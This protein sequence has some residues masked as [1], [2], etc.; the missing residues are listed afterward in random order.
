MPTSSLPQRR[1]RSERVALYSSPK[2][3]ARFV[4]E[5]RRDHQGL[6][7][8][9]MFLM[10]VGMGTVTQVWNPPFPFRLGMV[11]SR[12]I[13]CNTTFAVESP[14]GRVRAEERIRSE[15]PHIYFNDSQLLVQLRESLW[16]TVAVL[17]HVPDYDQL[18]A[19]GKEAWR[20][21]LRPSLIERELTRDP[22]QAFDEFY[23]YFK[24]DPKLDRFKA[25]LERV[26]TPLEVYGVLTELNFGPT[27]GNQERIMVYRLG[28][29]PD[30]AVSVKVSDALIRDG[31]RL[32]ELLRWEMQ[33]EPVARRIFQWICSQLRET[34]TKDDKATMNAINEAVAS[35]GVVMLEYV[36]GK[37]LVEMGTPLGYREIALLQA[38]YR[39]SLKK[40]TSQQQGLRF[41]AIT[42]MMLVLFAVC[43]GFVQRTERR[44]PKSR[45][46]VF[47][48]LGG[49][50]LTVA[51]AKGLDAYSQ[52]IA[53]WEM[54]PL[55][56]FVQL[57]SLIYSW[58]LAIVLST[59]LILFLAIGL[60][61]G[62]GM[63]IILLGTTVSMA[64]Q[65]GRLHF[66]HKLVVVSLV[67]GIVAFVLTYSVGILNGR[68]TDWPLFIESALNL[69][70]TMLA[71]VIMTALLPFVEEMFG[72]LTD[73]SLLELGNVSHPLL[74]SLVRLAPATYGHSM[75]VGTIAETAAEAVGARSLM[76]RV[77]AYYHDI[78][79]IMNPGYYSE[80]Q[81]GTGNIHDHLEPQVSTIVLVAHVKD[82]VDLVRQH[83]LPYP[84]IELVEQH[85]GTTVVSFFY[86]K[87]TTKAKDEQLSG[88]QQTVEESTFRY[89]GPKPQSKEAAILMIADTCESAC[90]SMREIATP[91]RLENKV[92]ALIKQKLD[93]GQLDDS[94]LT[95]RELKTIEN[96]VIKSVIAAF[97]GRVKYPGQEAEEAAIVK[98]EA[99]TATEKTETVADKTK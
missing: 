40:R 89:P 79:K 3:R 66:R 44:R 12:S 64:L 72:V 38:E 32:F 76:T 52:E 65:L 80:N 17:V 46:A 81:G 34:L 97:H 41:G 33:S 68:S 10:I 71:G 50:F 70:W 88:I 48:M 53:D 20:D 78:G 31:G 69:L 36:P 61:F 23:E 8:A 7:F 59:V 95:L 60:G 5:I 63:L 58:E 39:E 55:L 90:R 87:A 1:T 86:G 30:S 74:Q 13:I 84:I 99:A 2:S 98:N 57:V 43:W 19:K 77:G 75:A 91:S 73:M 62:N 45:K 67:S 24:N 54:L 37:T 47:A 15:T 42:L 26:F 11:P 4:E 28:E 49:M 29:S 83:R 92:R 93:D 82:G 51:F 25:T 96:S 6:L 16:N 85:H 35:V 14:E 94:G 56:I 22:K 27:E 9:L 21:F 18:D